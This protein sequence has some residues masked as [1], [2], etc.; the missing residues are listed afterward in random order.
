MENK[1]FVSIQE[2][3]GMMGKSVQTI[4]RLIKKGEIRA[5]RVKTPQ[6]FNYIIE[7]EDL[8]KNAGN[9]EFVILDNSPIQNELT[10]HVQAKVEPAPIQHEILTNQTPA[11][12]HA[13]ADYY[14]L[15]I[16]KSEMS[17]NSNKQL[18]KILEDSHREKMFLM[19]L[20]QKLQEELKTEREKEK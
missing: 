1:S 15:D 8:P 4:R 14:V 3:A 10:Q 6:G 16:Q 9:D 18:L 19:T 12:A 17:Q 7:L 11:Q 13:D 5:K 20:I 2:A